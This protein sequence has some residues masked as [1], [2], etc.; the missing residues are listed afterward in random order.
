MQV[1]RANGIVRTV[2]E[3]GDER[4]VYHVRKRKHDCIAKV[5][6]AVSLADAAKF[7]GKTCPACHKRIYWFSL[8]ITESVL[9]NHRG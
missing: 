9:A 8:P 3:V 4:P 1:Q 2:Y 7:R 5:G 6:T